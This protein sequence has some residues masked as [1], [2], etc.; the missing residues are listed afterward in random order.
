MHVMAKQAR[1]IASDLEEASKTLRL[2]LKDAEDDF[3][4]GVEKG[5]QAAKDHPKAALGIALG[6][7]FA[8]GAI[9][10]AEVVRARKKSEK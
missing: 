5:R 6:A 2:K 1:D 7:A 10:G 9:A 4:Q 3:R 8:A